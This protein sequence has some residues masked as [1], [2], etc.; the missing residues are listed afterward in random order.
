MNFVKLI[1]NMLF[2]PFEAQDTE[3]DPSTTGQRHEA[4]YYATV[5]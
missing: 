1:N 3:L 2:T 5:D 4:T